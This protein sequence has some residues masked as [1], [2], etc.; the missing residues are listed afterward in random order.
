MSCI[1]SGRRNLFYL[2]CLLV[3]LF[4]LTVVENVVCLLNLHFK[5]KLDHRFDG[6]LV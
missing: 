1:F 5:E 3:G 2:S 4:V 6:L